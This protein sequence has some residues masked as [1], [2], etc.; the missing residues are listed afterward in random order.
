MAN[1]LV[2]GYIISFDEGDGAK[3]VAIGSGSDAADTKV[4]AASPILFPTK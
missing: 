3:L 4:Q 1:G 2:I